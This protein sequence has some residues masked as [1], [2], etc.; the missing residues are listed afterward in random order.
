MINALHSSK[1]EGT[2]Q[3]TLNGIRFGWSTIKAMY[4]RECERAK[5]GLTR[6]VP[7]MKEVYIIRDSWTKL[8]VAPAKIMQVGKVQM[9]IC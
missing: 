9:L 7:K 6:M 3:F 4:Y 8:N 2:K 5:Q 1:D